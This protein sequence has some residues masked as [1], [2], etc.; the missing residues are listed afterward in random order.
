MSKL[1]QTTVIESQSCLNEAVVCIFDHDRSALQARSEIFSSAG[2]EVRPFND[3]DTFLEYARVHLPQVAVVDFGGS[4]ADG[5][6]VAA[7]VKEVSPKTSV[8]VSLKAHRGSA[9][10]ALPGTELMRMIEREYFDSST[11]MVS[12]GTC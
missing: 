5:P 6:K 3:P 1:G 4:N 11:G 2:W 10:E 9:R 12:S 8:M 7:R